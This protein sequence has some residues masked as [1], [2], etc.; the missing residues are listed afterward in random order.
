MLRVGRI[1]GESSA[2]VV[3]GRPLRSCAAVLLLR[4]VRA[5]PS[6]N[7]EAC[8]WELALGRSRFAALRPPPAGNP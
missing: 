1:A 6:V 3:P 8:A 5:A 2:R 4:H 7:R